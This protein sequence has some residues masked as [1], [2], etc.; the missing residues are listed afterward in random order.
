MK[1]HYFTS[2]ALFF[3][4]TFIS[5]QVTNIGKPLSW[6]Q[7]NLK[8]TTRIEM[9]SFD[10]EAITA[11]DKINDLD[12]TKPWRFGHEFT[13][14][15]GLD[16]SGTWD[17]L[18]NGDRIWRVNIISPGAKTLNFIFDTYKVPDGASVYLYTD[19]KSDLLGAYTNVMNR[20][21][22]MLGTWLVE[23]DNVWIEYYEPKN[24]Q[25][26]GK[27]NIGK[28][29]HGYRI[30]T[31]SKT[32]A[33]NSSGNCNLDVD[34][35]VGADFDGLK[36]RLKHSVAYIIMDGFVCTG[37]LINN[38]NNDKAPYFLT[39]NHC[40]AGTQST[41]SFRFNWI[42]PNP[43][44]AT[45]QN[46]S[47]ATITQ[48]TSG[49]TTLA[50]N[51][52]S[53][54]RLMSL[55]GGLDSS[56]DLEWGGWDRTDTAP[57]FVVGIH[58]PAGDIMKICRDDS[59]VIKDVNSGA[60]T[61]EIT[62]AGGGWEQGVTEGGSSGSA[63]FDENGRIIGQLFGGGA[64]CS[65][66]TDN[67]SFDYYGRFAVSWDQNN[68]GQWLDP[69]NTGLTTFNMYSQVL[70]TPEEELA[71]FIDIYPNPSTGLLNITNKTNSEISFSVYS[72]IGKTVRK[73]TL[74]DFQNKI[75]L[76]GL[77]DGI[78]MVKLNQ[79]KASIF[80]KIIISK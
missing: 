41:W 69:T 8:N 76:S 17:V 70:S 19:D 77:S 54:V 3:I 63:L 11:E 6:S 21:D 18:P 27:L 35:G 67:G 4:C 49:A 73:G 55:D 20:E 5:A 46:S 29:V 48:T 45:T 31:D 65:G 80:K 57:S 79:N 43:V 10:L 51:A 58:H 52:N 50:S 78:Y 61:W 72:I 59:G 26:L 22:E 15:H 53:D 56:W 39:A 23:G 42:S 28:V 32:D 13:V 71:N 1:K 38:T 68:F 40:N 24:V 66:T 9:N 34:C 44:C 25:G 30:S 75:D 37:Q 74:S 33:P 2:F 12:Q 16:N 36:D 60:Q 62:S 47:D 7:S 64:A 14:S